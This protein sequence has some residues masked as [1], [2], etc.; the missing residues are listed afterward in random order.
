VSGGAPFPER[1]LQPVATTDA[2]PP[3]GHYSQALACGDLVFLSAQLPLVAGGRMP[4]GVREQA[5]QVLRNCAQILQ[6][7]GSGLDQVVSLTL[8]VTDLAH[9]TCIDQAVGAAFGAHRPARAVLAV[10]ALHLGAQVAAQMIAA[11]RRAADDKSA[12]P[13]GPTDELRPVSGSYPSGWAG[14]SAV[15]VKDGKLS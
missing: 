8:Y 10:P 4:P 6:A 1:G 5:D 12:S 3:N 15:G 13:C 2:P 11:R 14:G 7:A 9:W